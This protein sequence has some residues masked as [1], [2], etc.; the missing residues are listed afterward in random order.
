MEQRTLRLGDIV[1]DY[2]P[3]ERR[4]TNHAIVAVVNDAIRQTRC[5]TCDADHPYKGGKEP[6]RRPARGDSNLFEQVLADVVPGQLVQPRPKVAVPE[7]GET[8][9]GTTE[10][11]A[12]V[13][14][15]H[16]AAD[17]HGSAAAEAGEAGD[18]TQD[19]SWP[20]NRPLIRATLPRTDN[21]PV[22]PRPIPEFTMHQRTPRGPNA[23]RRG[24]GQGWA[25]GNGSSP[26]GF[27][28]GRPAEG[29]GQG[30]GPGAPGHRPG[31]HRSRHKRSK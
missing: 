8:P 12:A 21:D 11:A 13:S 1:D 26:G 28:Q 27:R 7:P 10:A 6:R 14:A 15:E 2:C 19:E 4:I 30:A 25:S 5:T 3:R 22:I 24:Q 31:R 18:A 20:A 29:R 9:A 23:F 17:E 16:E